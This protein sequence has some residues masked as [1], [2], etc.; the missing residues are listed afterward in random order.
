[1][2]LASWYDKV[3]EDTVLAMVEETPGECGSCRSVMNGRSSKRWRT[4]TWRSFLALVAVALGRANVGCHV[5]WW[6]RRDRRGG[7]SATQVR[8]FTIQRAYSTQVG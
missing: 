7:T 4:Q 5:R 1:M 8:R 2:E 6:Y 3:E